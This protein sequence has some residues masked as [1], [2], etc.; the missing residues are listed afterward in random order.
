MTYILPAS[1]P[2]RK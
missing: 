2:H 1:F